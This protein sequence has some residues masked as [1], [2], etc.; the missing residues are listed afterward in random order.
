MLVQLSLECLPEP[1]FTNLWTYC[2][3]HVLLLLDDPFRAMYS[4]L[5]LIAV[6][7]ALYISLYDDDAPFFLFF[8]SRSG[9]ALKFCVN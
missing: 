1:W 7:G 9:L 3:V 5:I 8:K 4:L 2:C 6:T